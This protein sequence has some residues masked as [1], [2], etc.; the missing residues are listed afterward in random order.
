[1][2]DAPE[3][4]CPFGD[5]RHKRQ[6]WAAEGRSGLVCMNCSTTWEWVGKELVGTWDLMKRRGLI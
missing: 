4:L 6:P 5:G 3:K 2:S 1:M